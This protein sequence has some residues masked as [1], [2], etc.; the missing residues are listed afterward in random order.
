MARGLARAEERKE[1]G[2]LARIASLFLVIA[3]LL[4]LAQED[5][6]E[7]PW[8][9]FNGNISGTA[10]SDAIT[11]LWGKGPMQILWQI[12][13]A[14]EGQDRVTDWAPMTFDAAGNIYWKTNTWGGT[15]GRAR[16]VSVNPAGEIRWVANDGAAV[17]DLGDFSDCT[18]VVVGK[19]AVY[20]IGAVSAA[21]PLFVVAYD[22]ETGAKTWLTELDQSRSGT[23]G[24]GY[25]DLLT[26]VLYKGS[27]Y[28]IL[29]NDSE[30]STYNIYKVKAADGTLEWYDTLDDI[31][32]RIPRGSMT[33]VP[34]AFGAGE[35]GLYFNGDS[36]NGADGIPEV[37]AV[38]VMDGGAE[39]AWSVDGGKVWRSHMIYSAE[40]KTL[41]AH[42]FADYPDGVHPFWVYDP[43]TIYAPPT[44]FK[45]STGNAANNGGHGCYDVGC[46]DFNGTDVIAGAFSGFLV[47]YTDKGDEPPE[48][49]IAYDDPYPSN[50]PFFGEYRNYGQLIKGPDGH[51]I[52]ISGTNSFTQGSAGECWDPSHSARV[53][54]IDV[55]AG[56]LLWEF[57]TGIVNDHWLTVIGGSYAGPDGKIYYFDPGFNAG[58]ISGLVALVAA[59]TASFTAAPMSGNPP[60]EVS[61]DASGTT[62][63]G[64][65]VSYEWDFGDQT[66]GSGVTVKHTFANVGDYVVKLICTNSYGGTGEKTMTISAARVGTEFKRGDTN[67][68]GDM[69]IADPVYLLAYLF[70]SGPAPTCEETGDCNNDGKINIAD[71]VAA[72]AYLFASADPL[73]DPFPCGVDPPDDPVDDL[74]CESYAPCNGR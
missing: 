33:F 64:T 49:T 23:G 5:E 48:C 43:G 50:C 41:Y 66:A 42:T 30:P 24:G 69:N 17:H 31:T 47:R 53:V 58:H 67:A 26:P 11:H 37:W 73:P 60:L 22:K 45:H 57:D 54:A 59:P 13:L 35:H 55:T 19:N 6:V 4:V 21:D 10:S 44:T 71:P 27:L 65:I 63:V 15:G 72:L 7:G 40:T 3:P 29:P 18:A 28:L 2:M 61:F 51:S 68:S 12:D 56:E 46:L 20:A 52:L 38:K 74:T 16:V 39:L 62:S 34:D 8:G 36:G 70:A 9:T 14:A 25:V 1:A 32:Y